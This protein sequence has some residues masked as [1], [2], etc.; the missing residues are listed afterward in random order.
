MMM[1]KKNT[2]FWEYPF[3]WTP[4]INAASNQYSQKQNEIHFHFFE[5]FHFFST[6][7]FIFQCFFFI[8]PS[9]TFHFIQT[10]IPNGCLFCV[11]SPLSLSLCFLYR[12]LWLNPLLNPNYPA[13]DSTAKGIHAL[14]ASF[15]QWRDRSRSSCRYCIQLYIRAIVSTNATASM[16]FLLLSC[17]LFAV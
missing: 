5:F 9:S 8:D 16:Q 3:E 6:V 1:M 17:N 10:F 15:A 12:W 11:F 7:H 2:L 14:S 4:A 13:M